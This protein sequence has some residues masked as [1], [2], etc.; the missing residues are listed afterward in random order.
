MPYKIIEKRELAPHIKL[1]EVE[2]EEVALKSRPDHFVIP[3]VDEDGER[4][5]ITI[6][7]ADREKGIRGWTS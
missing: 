7:G 5:P 6:A 2:A 3:R 1:I 4:I